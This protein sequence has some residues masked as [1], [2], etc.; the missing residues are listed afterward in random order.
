MSECNELNFLLG[1]VVLTDKPTD[2]SFVYRAVVQRLRAD[3]NLIVGSVG[4]RATTDAY[5]VGESGSSRHLTSKA[6]TRR[7]VLKLVR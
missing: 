1:F 5:G 7:T 2:S 4:M 3:N 6:F